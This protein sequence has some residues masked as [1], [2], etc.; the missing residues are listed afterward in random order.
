MKVLP[1]RSSPSMQAASRQPRAQQL[2]SPVSAPVEFTSCNRLCWL[3]CL[4]LKGRWWIQETDGVEGEDRR[5]SWGGGLGHLVAAFGWLTVPPP[6]LSSLNYPGSAPPK[7]LAG[8]VL[9]PP[10]VSG[11]LTYPRPDF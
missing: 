9:A 2:Y 3:K 6:Q 5:W 10:T 4:I 11:W 7:E 1:W 8:F